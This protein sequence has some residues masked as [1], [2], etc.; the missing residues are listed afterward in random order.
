MADEN[1]VG[2]KPAAWMLI[3][4]VVLGLVAIGLYTARG[5]LFPAAKGPAGNIS[6]GDLPGGEAPEAP[7]VRINTVTMSA[8][9]A[10]TYLV[11]ELQ[12]RGGLGD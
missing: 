3:V 4:L 8:D 1:R 12:R 2:L 7:D 9:E 5:V 6:A 10:A 11:L